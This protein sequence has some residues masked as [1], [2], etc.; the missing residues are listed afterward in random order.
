MLPKGMLGL[1]ITRLSRVPAATRAHAATL[2]LV[3]A[4]ACGEDE[5]EPDEVSEHVELYLDDDVQV[6]AG[7]LDAYDRFIE[8]AFDVW[9]G[10]LPEDFVARVHVTQ[11]VPCTIS[12]TC[13]TPG[14]AWL[15]QQVGQFHELS[16]VIVGNRDGWSNP[17][18]TEGAAEALALVDI[19]CPRPAGFDAASGSACS[20][21]SYPPDCPPVASCL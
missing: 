8:R 13:A 5:R 20:Q 19:Q 14:N 11:E 12:D 21:S 3:L 4:V 6:C 17:A 10:G 2:I 18:L 1:P 16:H 7:Q 15:Q 9:A